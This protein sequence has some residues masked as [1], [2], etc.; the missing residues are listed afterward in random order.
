MKLI[1]LLD[2]GWGGGRVM[3][4]WVLWLRSATLGLFRTIYF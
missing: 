1:V 4:W 3:E 2:W